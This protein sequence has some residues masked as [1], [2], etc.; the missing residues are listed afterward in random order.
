LPRVSCA[1]AADAASNTRT[2]AHT[3][4]RIVLSFLL[5]LAPGTSLTP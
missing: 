4:L 3:R 5:Q 1:P 2:N